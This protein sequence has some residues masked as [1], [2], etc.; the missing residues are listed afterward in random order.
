[1][2]NLQGEKLLLR[3]FTTGELETLKGFEEFSELHAQ[4]V[5]PDDFRELCALGSDLLA[6]ENHAEELFA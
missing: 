3:S 2:K 5:S 1:M 4:A 6:L